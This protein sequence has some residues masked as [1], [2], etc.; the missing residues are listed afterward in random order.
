M[1]AEDLSRS[2]LYIYIPEGGNVEGLP[3]FFL[4]FVKETNKECS[5]ITSTV[6]GKNL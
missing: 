2:L 1:E 3:Q 4:H 5:E 6:V